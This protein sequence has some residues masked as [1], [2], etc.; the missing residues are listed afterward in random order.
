M[1]Q[2]V[3]A[4][5]LVP[6]LDDPVSQTVEQLQDV[7]QFFATCLPAVAE[8]VIEVPKINTEDVP[9]RAVLRAT[10]L[11]E[12][13]AE[14]PTKISFLMIVLYHAIMAQWTVEQNVDIPVA[15]GRGA[16]EGL[17]GFLL[18]QNSTALFPWS[19]TVDIPPGGGLQGFQREQSST[20]FLEQ[21]T[22]SP[23]PGGGPQKFQPVQGSAASSSVSPGHAGEGA[24]RTFPQ[25]KK[26]AT[27]HARS[28]SALPAH[29]SPWTPAPY[30]VPMALEE[31]EEELDEAEEV[32]EVAMAV[33]YVECSGRWWGQQWDPTA[34]QFCWWLA[35]ADG[36][37]LG[38]S[39]SSL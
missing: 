10:Q 17:S 20:A 1:E 25:M 34:Q 31:E 24:L 16:G 29:S 35:A 32:E 15:G 5:S 30:G 14:V 7:L 37:Q 36:S 38:H 8:P 9:M 28:W 18:R 39:I 6:L 11:V 3:D 4:V 12:Q 22:V 23:N 21:L 19:R 2:I 33:E 13:L 26:S 27:Q